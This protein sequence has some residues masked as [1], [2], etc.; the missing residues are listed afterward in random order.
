MAGL[1]RRGNFTIVA[2]KRRRVTGPR[3]LAAINKRTARGPRRTGSLRTQVKSLQR[4][5]KNLSP[6]QKYLDI[7]ADGT[8]VTTTGAVVHLTAIPQ[9]DTQGSRT[10]NTVNVTSVSILGQLNRAADTPL[11]ANAVYQVA[12]V[13]DKQQV[14][15]TVPAA[16]DI[17]EGVS[18]LSAFPDL[19]NL[20]RF[21]IIWMSPVYSNP[22]V[23]TDTDLGT[24]I[25]TQRVF[26]KKFWR[27]N[28]KVS[29]NGTAGTDIEKNGIFLVYL[30][31]DTN[32]VVDFTTNVRVG[33][34]DV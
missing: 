15:D 26:Y 19:A 33:Y 21:R 13:V 4:I 6:E 11:N 16:G 3:G 28:L 18:P 22:M 25:P 5:V 12:L 34:T 9:G 8:N 2:M 30:S 32:N 31:N 14:A 27:T 20:E 7:S 24:Q 17:F 23:V 29:Y 1:K 10:G